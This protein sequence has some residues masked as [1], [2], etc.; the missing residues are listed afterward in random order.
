N[1]LFTSIDFTGMD[2]DYLSHND[3]CTSYPGSGADGQIKSEN[4]AKNHAYDRS[5]ILL[6]SCYG[7]EVYGC[8]FYDLPVRAIFG[9][10]VLKNITIDSCSFV[11]LG[12]NAIHF[13]DATA[14]RNWNSNK[15]CVENMLITNN[16]V[17]DVGRVYFPSAGIWIHYGRNLT[18]TYNTV[19]KVSWSAIALGF[20]YGIPKSDPS[21]SFCNLYNVEVAY[22]YVTGFMQNIGDGGGIYLTGGNAPIT[23]LGY[24]NY[25]HHNYVL[26]S[27]G[28]GD[29][30]GH[31]VTGIYFDGS[32]SNWHC[33]SNVVVE[34]SYGAVTG[35]DD[36]FDM[37]NEDDVKYLTALRNRYRGSTFIY[38]Q[39][40]LSQ[41]THNNFLDNNYVLN[42]RATDPKK[43][44]EEVYKTYIVKERNI[45]E[46]NTHYINGVERIPASAEDIICTA[47][48][49]GH[50][51]DPSLLW[52]NNY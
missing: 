33:H 18:V 42:V 16:Y 21:E 35:E 52:D 23:T 17:H 10:G 28:T 30:L 6:D 8:D 9:K 34:Q 51:G 26:M 49:Y 48:S 22:N 3:G 50:E 32:A 46:Q 5:V 20:T 45:I 27:N 14:E 12:S 39:H 4:E 41:I 36:G 40:I 19:D 7:L 25:V 1:V 29:G 15:N 31:M 37:S 44:H 24:F 13:G 43:Q 2:D 11:N 38:M 47:G